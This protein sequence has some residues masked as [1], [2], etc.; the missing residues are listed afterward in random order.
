MY[1]GVSELK[2]AH[3]LIGEC[4]VRQCEN[5]PV[6]NIVLAQ[7]SKPYSQLLLASSTDMRYSCHALVFA[8]VLFLRSPQSPPSV[9]SV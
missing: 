7:N 3:V 6:C 5:V 1:D 8:V 9:E 4:L 2:H